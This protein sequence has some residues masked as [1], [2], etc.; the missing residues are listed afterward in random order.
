MLETM[1]AGFKRQSY[2][3]PCTESLLP[4]PSTPAISA[5]SYTELR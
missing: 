3:T 2:E 1:S 5:I 4:H